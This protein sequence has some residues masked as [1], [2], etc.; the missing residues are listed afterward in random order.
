MTSPGHGIDA[1]TPCAAM[2]LLTIIH[3]C[4][5]VYI[6]CISHVLEYQV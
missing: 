3:V 5:F 4:L 6:Y 2:L 1:G